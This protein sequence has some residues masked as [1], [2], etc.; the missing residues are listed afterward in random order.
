MQ[1]AIS[2]GSSVRISTSV[3]MIGRIAGRLEVEAN[4]EIGPGHDAVEQARLEMP[5]DVVARQARPVL[6]AVAARD[7]AVERMDAAAAVAQT[8][9]LGL[10]GFE[11]E[12][13]SLKKFGRELWL[14]GGV[15]DDHRARRW[16]GPCGPLAFEDR[17]SRPCA[18]V[19]RDRAPIA[20]GAQMLE[21]DDV[22]AMGVAGETLK[23][24]IAVKA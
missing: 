24:A 6:P 17:P 8:V 11:I 1:A 22:A 7:L 16:T 18:P 2:A 15:L 23:A 4:P 12:P 10:D 9:R 14:L 5:L 20:A 21:L 13:R 3:T 19:L